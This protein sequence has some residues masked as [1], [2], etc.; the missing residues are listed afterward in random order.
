MLSPAFGIGANGRFRLMDAIL[1]Q[2][3]AGHD[4]EAFVVRRWHSK[5]H[6]HR[7]NINGQCVTLWSR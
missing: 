2:T 4:P 5:A 6:S 7:A 3:L 1:V